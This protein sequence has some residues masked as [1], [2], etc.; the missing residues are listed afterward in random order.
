MQE[1]LII[2]RVLLG[3]YF[4]ISGINHFRMVKSLSN[5]AKSKNVPMSEIVVV[6]TGLLLLI[7]GLSILLWSY[8]WYGIGLLV[9]FLFFVTPWMHAFWKVQ[10]VERMH[11]MRYFLGNYAMVGALLIIAVLA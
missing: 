7:G 8:L 3:V 1:V 9:I 6:A 10:G 2:G 11:Q 5:H 4:M